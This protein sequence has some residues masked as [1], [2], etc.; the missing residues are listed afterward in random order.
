MTPFFNRA[1]SICEILVECIMRD[2]SAKS[3]GIW[4]SGSGGVVVKRHFLSSALVASLFGGVEP[5]VQFW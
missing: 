5:F 1:V 2:N 3:F 4:T